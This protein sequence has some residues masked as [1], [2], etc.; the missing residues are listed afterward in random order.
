[1]LVVYLHKKI[2]LVVYFHLKK[3]MLV[4]CLKVSG[5]GCCKNATLIFYFRDWLI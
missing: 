5:I 1:M 3:I 4:A 2:M